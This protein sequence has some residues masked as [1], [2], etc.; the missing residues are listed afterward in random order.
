MTFITL[1]DDPLHKATF[2]LYTPSDLSSNLIWY[3]IT[4]L[5]PVEE[6]AEKVIFIKDSFRE[7]TGGLV[8][9]GTSAATIEKG[10]DPTPGPKMFLA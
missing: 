9:V 2:S 6:G 3:A 8:Y 5:L 4:G 10:F 7:R 1:E